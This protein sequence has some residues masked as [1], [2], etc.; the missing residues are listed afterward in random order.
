MRET[1][2][3]IERLQKL[4]DAS[5]EKGGEHLK[6]II[7][8]ERRLTAAQLCEELQGM[9]LLALATVSAKGEPVVGPVD[10]V[11]FKGQFIFGSAENSVRFKH[12]RA[13]PA[14]SATHFRG[15]ELVVTVHG[16]A[17][18]L[19]KPDRRYDELKDVYREIYG[20]DWDGWNYWEEAPYAFIEPRAIFAASFKGISQA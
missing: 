17:H 3:D 15:E 18:E 7:T 8:P 5:Y 2:E 12:I 6:G 13:R 19:D 20:G 9:T 4:L 16:Y 14:V 10:G 11:L 1:P